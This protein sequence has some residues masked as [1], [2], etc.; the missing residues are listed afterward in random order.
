MQQI[1]RCRNEK[2]ASVSYLSFVD[3]SYGDFETPDEP[4]GHPVIKL[5]G[6]TGQQL[7]DHLHSSARGHRQFRFQTRAEPN[8][9]PRRPFDV[10]QD[11]H[12]LL[13]HAELLQLRCI[14]V[15]QQIG[16][17]AVPFHPVIVFLISSSHRGISVREIAD[18]QAPGE[19]D[20]KMPRKPVVGGRRAEGERGE[21]LG[22]IAIWVRG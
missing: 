16:T 14:T 17:G 12:G 4:T 21:N 6:R 20:V 1:R 11:E 10:Q 15:R 2:F 7:L 13:D 9:V 19:E 22:Q 3:P 8:H 18:A 5:R